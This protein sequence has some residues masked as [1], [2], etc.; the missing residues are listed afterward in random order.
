MEC[1]NTQTI[2]LIKAELA[3]LKTKLRHV[4]IHNHWLRQEIRRGTIEVEYTPST[5]MKADGL[6]KALPAQKWKGFLDQVGLVDV[7]E[8][9]KDRSPTEDPVGAREEILSQETEALYI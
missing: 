5:E 2:K 4:D 8:R 9:Q 7:Q 6:T 3:L 1:D